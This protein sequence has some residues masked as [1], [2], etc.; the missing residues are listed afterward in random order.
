M[1]LE[2][3][4]YIHWSLYGLPSIHMCI[5]AH[6]HTQSKWPTDKS[7][8]VDCK[9]PVWQQPTET[10]LSTSPLPPQQL[11]TVLPYTRTLWLLWKIVFWLAIASLSWEQR[12][13]LISAMF[14]VFQ[15]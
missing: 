7:N 4:G 8:H 1:I 9:A 12:N 10:N 5:N 13:Y 14:S 6:I 15:A 3:Q 11:K 2:P